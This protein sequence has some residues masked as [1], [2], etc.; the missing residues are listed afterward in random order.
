MRYYYIEDIKVNKMLLLIR[1]YYFSYAQIQKGTS[2]TPNEYLFT[3]FK[4]M[5]DGPQTGGGAYDDL[6]MGNVYLKAL[7]DKE[8]VCPSDDYINVIVYSIVNF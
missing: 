7:G 3:G 2:Y 1:Y 5:K 4:K 8:V 6:G